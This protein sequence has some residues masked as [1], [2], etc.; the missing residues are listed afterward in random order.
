MRTVSRVYDNYA[1]A[2]AVVTDLEA[3]VDLTPNCQISM[4]A[5][6]NAH[7]R[8]TALDTTRTE[9]NIR[10]RTGRGHWGDSRRWRRIA[11]RPWAAGHPW[12][13]SVGR[14]W[15]V[16]NDLGRRSDWRGGGWHRRRPR[17]VRR[18]S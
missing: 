14:R 5:N 8:D 1:D 17:Q 6:E 15:L 7:G 11:D 16:G 10:S 4:I 12:S 13:G 18:A 2:V 9:T 3:A